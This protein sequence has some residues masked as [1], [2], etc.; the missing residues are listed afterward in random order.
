MI[1]IVAQLENRFL[2]EFSNTQAKKIY[3][4][5]PEKLR[6]NIL[7]RRQNCKPYG[8]RADIIRWGA[9]DNKEI[10]YI[11][12]GN[13]EPESVT[14][15]V[16]PNPAANNTDY[17]WYTEANLREALSAHP[18][19]LKSLVF[20]K[21]AVDGLQRLCFRDISWELAENTLPAIIQWTRKH[22]NALLAHQEQQGKRIAGSVGLKEF[23]MIALVLKTMGGSAPLNDICKKY[24]ALFGFNLTETIANGVKTALFQYSS[25]SDQ[26]LGQKDL[27]KRVNEDVWALRS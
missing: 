21:T 12:F 15:Y 3:E 23:E 16:M 10:E 2:S 19:A 8:T 26:F 5:I 9:P 14:I 13:I 20:Q 25:D 6:Q 22:Q 1:N 4:Q 24:A 17:S 18:E 11:C 27:F 7:I